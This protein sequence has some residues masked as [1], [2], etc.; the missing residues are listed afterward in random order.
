[1]AG[2][3]F[4]SEKFFSRGFKDFAVSFKANPNTKDVSAV[5]NANAIK[6][7]VRNLILTQFGERPYQY[8]IGSRVS[9]LLFEPFDVFLAE[10]LRDEIYNCISRLEPRV[11]VR[12]ISV[13]PS[14]DENEIDIAINYA[15][16]G[17]QVTQVVQFILE[18]T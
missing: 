10:D 12:S 13:K 8:D 7:S 15:I 11:E 2:Y 1:M 17:Q 16:V 3:T 4:R 18:R 6:Q 9:G 5:S 14:I